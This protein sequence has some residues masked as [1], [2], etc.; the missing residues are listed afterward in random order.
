MAVMNDAQLSKYFDGLYIAKEILIYLL[1]RPQLFTVLL[2]LLFCQFV[3]HRK[4]M[5]CKILIHC[6]FVYF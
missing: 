3:L 6:L 1:F 4:P 5:E 2:S